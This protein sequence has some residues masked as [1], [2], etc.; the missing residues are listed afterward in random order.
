MNPEDRGRHKVLFVITTSDVGGTESF[1]AN[2]ALGLDRSRFIPSVCSLCP[3]GRAGERIADGGVPVRSLGMSAG[4]RPLQLISGILRL[5]RTID[6]EEIDLVQAL[7]YRANMMSAL[8]G[9][10]ARRSVAV[11]GGQRSLTPMTGQRAALGVRWTRR[12]ARATVA[13]SEAVKAEIV[14][15]ER[16]A[17]DRVEVI[18]NGVD[19]R[20]FRPGDRL[21]ARR[22]LG[23]SEDSLLVGAVGRLSAAK[24]FEHLIEAIAKVETGGQPIELALVGDGPRRQ[25]LEDLARKLGVGDRVRLLGR[26]DGLERIYPAFDVFVLSSLREG[27]P[28]V[29][30]E[31]MACGIA[32]IATRVGGVPEIVEPDQSCV[33]VAPGEAHAI[34]SALEQLAKA[35]EL[36][37]RL[38]AAARARVEA[39]LTNDRMIARHE[40]LYAR[41]LERRRRLSQ[42]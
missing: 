2:L 28:N 35:P 33:L 9:V 16:L 41:L 3:V 5:A 29:L 8:A 21:T 31:A 11:V 24:G 27:S 13:V 37:R 30:F 36:R 39:E 42:D 19:H 38:G 20:R 15:G 6:T 40:R 17:P 4:A 26:R 7:L 1:L 14:A 12:L 22:E 32:S 23:L 18:G 10:L 34:A 25:P